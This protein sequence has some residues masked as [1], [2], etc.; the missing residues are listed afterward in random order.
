MLC[1]G[2]TCEDNWN[3]TTILAS[4]I[5][6]YEESCCSWML[7]SESGQ[8]FGEKQLL[9]KTCQVGILLSMHQNY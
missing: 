1:V 8:G 7:L 6:L 4:G 2:S 5:S 3:G 9:R